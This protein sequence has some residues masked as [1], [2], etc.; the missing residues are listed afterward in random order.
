VTKVEVNDDRLVAYVQGLDQVLA[1]K[2]ELTIPL[3]QVKSGTVSPRTTQSRNAFAI[4][5]DSQ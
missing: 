4:A 1:V 2:S 5:N 3:A